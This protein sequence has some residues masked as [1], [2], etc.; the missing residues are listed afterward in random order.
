MIDVEGGW[1]QVR[2]G[3]DLPHGYYVD[4]VIEGTKRS[5]VKMVN[6]N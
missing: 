2:E 4:N 1:C 6:E 5:V 3:L